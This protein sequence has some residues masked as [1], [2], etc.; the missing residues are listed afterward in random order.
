MIQDGAEAATAVSL[1]LTQLITDFPGFI[2][3][4]WEWIAV[5]AAILFGT[6]L[7]F[8]ILARVAKSLARRV[9]DHESLQSAQLLEDTV[10]ALTGKLVFLFGILLA[11]SFVGVE[12]RPLLAGL[13]IAGFVLGFALQDSLANFAAGTMILVYAPFDVGDAVEIAGVTGKVNNMSLVSTT[14]NTFDNQRII[15]PNAK[16]WGD[17][18]KNLTAEDKRRVDM[19]FGIGYEDDIAKAEEILAE[20][21]AGHPLV[22][23]DPEP[24]IKLANLG[25][26]SVDFV[27]RPWCRTED[28]WDVKFDVT[29]QVKLAL[30]EAGI[31]IPY[32]QRDVHVHTVEAGVGAE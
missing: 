19:T 17:V 14:V 32:P 13:G 12:L 9:A 3:D 16:I 23:E 22:L 5:K 1:D 18:I 10:V 20:I 15:I 7:V 31:S 27:V 30:N 4:N 2:S 21:I 8:W 6:I 28:Y 25:D 26:S 11:L 29:R 24:I